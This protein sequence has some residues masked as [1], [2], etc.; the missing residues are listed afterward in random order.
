MGRGKAK[1]RSLARGSSDPIERSLCDEHAKERYSVVRE[2]QKD[3]DIYED[4]ERL[5]RLITDL[6]HERGI[7]PF[8][9]AE[10]RRVMEDEAVLG[11]E[12]SASTAE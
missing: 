3:H 12:P 7:E 1:G 9:R 4:F 6:D 2:E 10:L 5:E 8:T 11:E